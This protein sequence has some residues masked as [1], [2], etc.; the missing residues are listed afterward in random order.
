MILDI[1]IL[2]AFIYIRYLDDPFVLIVA[3]TTIVF[4][5]IAERLFMLSHTDSEGIMYMGMNDDHEKN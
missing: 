5:V 3:F 2:S 4:I 1:I